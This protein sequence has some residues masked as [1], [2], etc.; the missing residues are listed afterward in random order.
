MCIE[1]L[2]AGLIYN[3]FDGGGKTLFSFFHFSNCTMGWDQLC[4]RAK[5]FHVNIDT[6]YFILMFPCVRTIKQMLRMCS[7]KKTR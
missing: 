7:Q 3:N 1:L 6:F 5:K 2:T 4:I